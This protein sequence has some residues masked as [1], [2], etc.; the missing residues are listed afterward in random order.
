[1]ATHVEWAIRTHS[2]HLMELVSFILR[3]KQIKQKFTSSSDGGDLARM[4]GIH[5]ACLIAVTSLAALDA[6]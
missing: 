6:C 4:A 1:M 3:N 5:F 2:L